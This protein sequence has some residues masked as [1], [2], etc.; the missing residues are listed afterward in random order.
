MIDTHTHLYYDNLGIAAVRRAVEKGVDRFLFPNVDASSIEPMKEL[1]SR[2]GGRALMA[3]GLHPT[4]LGDDM[5]AQLKLILDELKNGNYVAVG[6]VGIDLYWDRSTLPSQMEA[7]DIQLTAAEQAGLPVIIHCREGFGPALEVMS[8]HK[9]VRAVFH[10]FTGTAADIDSVRK[11][12]DPFFGIGGVVT[13]KNSSLSSLL[14]QIGLDR[15]LTE[16]DSP[17]LAPVPFRGK[18]NESAYIP[19]IVDAIARALGRTADEVAQATVQNAVNLI[20]Q[21][22]YCRIGEIS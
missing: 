19:V 22:G 4:E 16:T 21:F 12:C 3:M 1:A 9:N 18:T 7:F 5:H 10:C 11:V 6:E 13:F 14:P 2:C 17:Y 8:A 20:P 15:I